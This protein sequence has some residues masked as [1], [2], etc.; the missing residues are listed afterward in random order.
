MH[1]PPLPPFLVLISVRGWVNPRA[2]V[3]PEGLCQWKNP[4][5]P[6]GIKPATFRLV[7]QCLNQ[8]CHHMPHPITTWPLLLYSLH[9]W[10]HQCLILYYCI[11]FMHGHIN[12]SYFIIVF[13]SCMAT[14]MSH[15]LF[16]IKF[17]PSFLKLSIFLCFSGWN[18]CSSSCNIK[19]RMWCHI[20]W[21]WHKIWTLQQPF[22]FM[23]T[24]M[25]HDIYRETYRYSTCVTFQLYA[26]VVGLYL[27][28]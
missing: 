16:C 4:V 23:E 8:L 12:I 20:L 22:I 19:T 3:W 14:S 15:T 11:H 1:W 6:S 9:A 21:Q 17:K 18:K 13:T 7:A 2:I 25:Q 5:T 26:Q 24:F 27:S 28:I 10:P